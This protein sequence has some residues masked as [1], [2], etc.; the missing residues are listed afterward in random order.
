MAAHERAARTGSALLAARLRPRQDAKARRYCDAECCEACAR[1]AHCGSEE[2]PTP[3]S[4]LGA[5][6]VQEARLLAPLRACKA[7]PTICCR[8]LS[9]LEVVEPIEPHVWEVAGP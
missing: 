3:S 5:L 6:K 7:A 9:D 2:E 1:A 8:E 4:V